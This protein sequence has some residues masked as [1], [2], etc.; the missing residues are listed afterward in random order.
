MRVPSAV[1]TAPIAR[2]CAC[3]ICA[4]RHRRLPASAPAR[5]GARPHVRRLGVSQI[6]YY[7]EGAELVIA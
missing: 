7:L 1:L 5:I 6:E 2:L 3:C 4:Y